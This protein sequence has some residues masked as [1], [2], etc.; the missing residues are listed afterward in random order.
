M[1]E[2]KKEESRVSLKLYIRKEDSLKMER[3]V[4]TLKQRGWKR[5]DGILR[6]QNKIMDELFL[7]ADSNFYEDIINRL[8][9]L[10]YLCE[11]GM[12]NPA[13]RKELERILKRKTGK[14]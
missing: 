14:K 3:V 13:V 1:E 11:E 5:R 2:I 6:I 4:N 8:T 7:K 12:K 10:E 9:P